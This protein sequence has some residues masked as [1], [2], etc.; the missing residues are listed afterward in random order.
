MELLLLLDAAR[1]V[2]GFKILR[3]G[4]EGRTFQNT[5]DRPRRMLGDKRLGVKGRPAKGREVGMAPHIPES[6]ADISQ[7]S[8]ALDA[9]DRRAAEKGAELD[10]VEGQV[11]TQWHLRRWPGRES[12]LPGG[13][14]EAVP[15]AGIQTVIAT[16]DAIADERPELGWNRA[17]Q[18]DR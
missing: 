17:F 14:G 15:G 8:P 2:A 12:R 4:L 10:I 1:T 18:F 16:I 7:K 3:R 13:G 6:D 9:F 11:V 5:I